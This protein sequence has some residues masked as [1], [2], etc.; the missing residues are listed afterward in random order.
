MIPGGLCEIAV[1]LL[2]SIRLFSLP[3][4]G[5]NSICAKV[6][7]ISNV[8]KCSHAAPSRQ[9][10]SERGEREVSVRDNP[11]SVYQSGLIRSVTHL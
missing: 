1:H 11:L 6:G 7:M 2:F 3:S 9:L 8:S 5:T 10:T 4:S